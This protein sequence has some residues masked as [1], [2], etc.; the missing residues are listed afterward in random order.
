MV[1]Y[2]DLE[3]FHL[4]VADCVV[5]C[6]TDDMTLDTPLANLFALLLKEIKKFDARMNLIKQK[7]VYTDGSHI[8]CNYT[9]AVVKN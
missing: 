5:R 7:I 9:T 4:F 3:Y 2:Y 6:I 1:K 8:R